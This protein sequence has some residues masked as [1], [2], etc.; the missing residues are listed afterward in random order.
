[1]K[2]E[3]KIKYENWTIFEIYQFWLYP[4][5]IIILDAT[6]SGIAGYFNERMKKHES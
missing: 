1:M 5:D 6:P 3:L 2:I 4:T